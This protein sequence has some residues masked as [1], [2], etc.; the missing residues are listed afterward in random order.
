MAKKRKKDRSM[1]WNYFLYCFG[2]VL[3]GSY[4]V[5]AKNL[6]EQLPV[7][8]TIGIRFLIATPVFFLIIKL[9]KEKFPKLTRK[10]LWYLFLQSATGIFLFNIFLFYGLKYSKGVEAGIVLSL[11]PALVAILAYFLLKEKIGFNKVIGVVLTI[12]GIITINLNNILGTGD[13]FAS[14]QLLGV[15][16]ILGVAF[17]EALFTIFGKYNSGNMS[18]YQLSYAITLIALVLFLPIFIIEAINVDYTIFT[19]QLI[20]SL[21]YYIIFTGIISYVVVYYALK[22]L[23]ASVAGVLTGLIPISGILLS[24]FFLG[25]TVSAMF[26]LGAA[27]SLIGMYITTKKEHKK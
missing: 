9:R 21:T 18:P 5:V 8:F 25:E 11:S 6:T 23:E 13:G 22:H 17:C 26:V 3:V 16:L 4:V 27:I 20:F 14:F 15:I 12:M 2:M 1:F 24:I 19:L 10:D 7:F